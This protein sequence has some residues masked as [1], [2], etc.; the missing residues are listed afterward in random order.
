VETKAPKSAQ[1]QQS[2]GELIQGLTTADHAVYSVKLC[3]RKMGVRKRWAGGEA[4]R[5]FVG[6]LQIYHR[7]LG[8]KH[9]NGSEATLEERP[10]HG[11]VQPS[12]SILQVTIS[13]M[14]QRRF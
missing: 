13:T 6:S 11:L 1:L 4:T 8:P 2:L 9:T 14:R 3:N 5:G 10:F 7:G 12:Q